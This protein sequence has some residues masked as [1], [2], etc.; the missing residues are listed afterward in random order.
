MD[1]VYSKIERMIRLDDAL[2]LKIKHINLFL[3]KYARTQLY[4]ALPVVL[5][6]WT[7][8]EQVSGTSSLSD[9]TNISP[10]KMGL[11]L[12][13]MECVMHEIEWSIVQIMWPD[14]IS[15]MNIESCFRQSQRYRCT[16]TDLASYDFVTVIY[17]H[18]TNQFS[19]LRLP[20]VRRLQQNLR[21]VLNAFNDLKARVALFDQSSLHIPF[22]SKDRIAK[23]LKKYAVDHDTVVEEQLYLRSAINFKNESPQIYINQDVIDEWDMFYSKSVLRALE[24]FQT[25]SIPY[26]S[27]YEPPRPTVDRLAGWSMTKSFTTLILNQS[28]IEVD[29]RE[30]A[31][32]ELSD[33]VSNNAS[34]ASATV[35]SNRNNF[36]DA[37]VNIGT[38]AD[39]EKDI[40]LFFK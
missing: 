11:A 12:A 36:A 35:F 38:I 3:G 27:Y 37:N 22:S 5:K 28:T 19:L 14:Y 15:A 33:T 6:T 2:R 39:A 10:E 34:I 17:S 32:T 8:D 9:T 16:H 30:R 20:I 23:M 26:K 40:D 1:A 21:F 25:S 24:T 13:E 18:A 4:L 31:E 7:E 29:L